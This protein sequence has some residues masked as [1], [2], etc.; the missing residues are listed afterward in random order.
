MVEHTSPDGNI[1]KLKYNAYTDI[2]SFRDNERD[3]TIDYTPFGNIARKTERNQS[4]EFSYNSQDELTKIVN[5]A[6]EEYT[7]IRNHKGKVIEEIGYDN[8]RKLYNYSRAGKLTGV[9]RGNTAFWTKLKYSKTGQLAKIIYDDETKD[10]PE[11][12]LFTYNKAG[13]LL[14]AKN[15]DITLAFEYDKLGN[16]TKQIQDNHEV[17][18]EYNSPYMF[19]RTK[20]KSSLGLD[21]D[22]NTTLNETT[23][24]VLSEN[25]TRWEHKET[26][27]LLGQAENATIKIGNTTITNNWTYDNIGRPQ[28]Q[29]ASIN[30][31]EKVRKKYTWGL[32]T[33][34]KSILDE[35]TNIGSEYSYGKHGNAETETVKNARH[36]FKPDENP[37]IRYLDE[38]GKAYKVKSKTDRKY[39]AG[40]Q[41]KTSKAGFVE[42]TYN[43]CGDLIEKYDKREKERWKYEYNINGLMSK[44]IR[45]DKKEV[46]FKY[47]PL[48]RRISKT[49]EGVTTKFIWDSDKIIHEWKESKE[50]AE[51]EPNIIT[52]LYDENSFIPRLKMTETQT[53]TIITDH[54]GTPYK[55]VN[56]EGK[57]TWEAIVNIWG[58]KKLLVAEERCPFRFQGQYEDIE[59]GLY[60]NRF[61]YYMPD[62]GIYTQRDPIGLAGGNPTVY[63]YGAT[64]S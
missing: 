1:T 15:K 60:Y 16:V 26:Y 48:G 53:N 22:I 20:L 63:G 30:S 41:L 50:I 59:A 14:E 35:I 24:A 19:M 28:V 21:L 33:Q 7:F 57:V 37:V 45:P 56:Q 42:Y 31:R 13:Q 3:I 64:R 52:W 11:E 46:Y 17:I 36:L 4:I 12:E 44:V 32:G 10:D 51:E 23:M 55:M 25:E 38:T 61:R 29:K 6:N 9:K 58:K 8:V 2:I 39:H 47:D 18:S 54:L 62:E 49:F 5:E 40:G 27:N 43:D 34:I